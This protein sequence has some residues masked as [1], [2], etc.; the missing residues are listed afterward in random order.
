[1]KIINCASTRHDQL[2]FSDILKQKDH[3]LKIDK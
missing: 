2:L 3:I 1:M